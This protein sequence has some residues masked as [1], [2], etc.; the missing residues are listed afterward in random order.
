VLNE[1]GTGVER[2]GAPR[3]INDNSWGI[4][5]NSLKENGYAAEGQIAIK[6]TLK[7]PQE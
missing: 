3:V 4:N 6:M 2:S 5:D 7:S 1:T